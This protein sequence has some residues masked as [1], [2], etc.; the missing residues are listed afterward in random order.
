MRTER[1]LVTSC[2]LGMAIGSANCSSGHLPV[3]AKDA[4]TLD[5]GGSAGPDAGSSTVPDGVTYAIPP[6]DGGTSPTQGC[7]SPIASS[8]LAV[9]V[10]YY[11]ERDLGKCAETQGCDATGNTFASV[12]EC[13][14]A[15][16]RLLD[17]SC[18]AGAGPC[19]SQGLCGTCPSPDLLADLTDAASGLAC[20]NPG[21]ICQIRAADAVLWRCRCLAGSDSI[22]WKCEI[23]ISG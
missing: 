7:E 14:T 3:P 15:C 17:C 13:E 12:A 8:C 11:F 19:D 10:R 4:A 20:L 21:L 9:D 1:F 6:S 2:I 18:T 16:I 22:A 5:S 23:P